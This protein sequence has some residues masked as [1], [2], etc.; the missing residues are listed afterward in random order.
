LLVRTGRT[1]DGQTMLENAI[2]SDPSLRSELPAG[3]TV[4]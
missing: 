3:I 2:H 4:P 1:A